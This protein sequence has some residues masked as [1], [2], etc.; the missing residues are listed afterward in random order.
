MSSEKRFAKAQRA[1]DFK[2]LWMVCEAEAVIF[3]ISRRLSTLTFER[4]APEKFRLCYKV[5][6]VTLSRPK[7]ASLNIN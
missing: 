4:L 6:F 5:F 1:R 3:E 2:K 7:K